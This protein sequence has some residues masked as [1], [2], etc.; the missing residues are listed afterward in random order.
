MESNTDIKTGNAVLAVEGMTCGTCARRVESALLGLPGVTQATVD[1]T[2]GRA[3]FE[4]NAQP[5]ESRQRCSPPATAPVSQKK[6]VNSL[7][8]Q[9]LAKGAAADPNRAGDPFNIPL[10]IVYH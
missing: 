1:R 7:R 8:L 9:P 10:E 2:S 3:Y 4:G 5:D 6:M